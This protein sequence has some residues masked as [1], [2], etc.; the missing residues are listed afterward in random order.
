MI[1]GERHY[2][3][4]NGY[5]GPGLESSCYYLSFEEAAD[6][7]ERYDKQSLLP[8][9]WDRFKWKPFLVTN[10]PRIVHHG[11]FFPWRGSTTRLPGF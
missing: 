3:E 6:A 4:Q 7:A 5:A 1:N 2:L 8:S 9:P 10:H 11:E